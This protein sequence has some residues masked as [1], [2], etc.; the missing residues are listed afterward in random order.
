MPRRWIIFTVTASLFFLSQFYRAT[1]AVIAPELVRDLSLTT[2]GLGTLSAAFFY[3]FALTQIPISILLDRVGARIMMTG[4]SLIGVAGALI[5][6]GSHSLLTGSLGRALLG[7]GMACNLMGT[8]KLLTVWFGPLSFATLSGVVFS[9]GT[10][11]NMAA[12]T[13]L[14]LLVQHLGWRTAFSLIAGV[15]LVLAV[16]LYIVVRD[17]PPGRARSAASRKSD[18][19]EGLANLRH[20]LRN[21]N[22]WIISLGTFTRY[23]TLA[24]F[25]AL[26]AGPYLME[27]M[28]LSP[29]STGNLIFLMN[30]G[31]I[32]GGPGFGALSDR[33]FR[34][35]KWIILA[36]LLALS[37]ITFV[38]AGLDPGTGVGLLACL[39]FALGFFSASG[40][41][42]YAH[43]KEQMPTEMAGTA[44]TGINFFTMTGAAVFMQGLAAL[45]EALYPDA[46]RGPEA[47]HAALTVCAVCL[48]G[49][50]FLYLATREP[51]KEQGYP[52]ESYGDGSKPGA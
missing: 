20:L 2:E 22:Y 19:L 32:L 1:N 21:R 42:M 46:S 10:A 43:I 12:T 51:L 26:W 27:V 8:F 33:I 13:P 28:R 29:I 50:S 49:V 44:M 5:F 35:R 48:L 11:G 9:I 52:V 17:H 23:G 25:Q 31:L 3:A 37:V 4:L 24:A 7:L 38:L 41:L 15:N 36:G 6:A 47:F 39:F 14:V 30:M 34:T 18:F 16:I 45:M 40:M